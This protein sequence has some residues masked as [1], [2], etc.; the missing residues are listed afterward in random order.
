MKKKSITSSTSMLSER[1]QSW[2]LVFTLPLAFILGIYGYLNYPMGEEQVSFTNAM[3]HAAQLFI[4]HT[5]HFGPPVP[6]SLEIARWLAA[7]STGLVL[8]NAVLHI[9]HR[10]RMKMV[11]KLRKQHAIVCGLGRRGIAVTEKLNESGIPVVAID[12]NPEPE[13]VE[14]LHS[15]G[16]PLIIGD[17]TRKE[18]LQQARIEFADHIYTLCPDDTTN[19]SIALEAHNIKCSTGR[20]RE[21]FIHINDA[22]LRNVLQNNYQDKK[23]KSSQILN[24]IDAYSTEAISLLAHGLPLDHDGIKAN[25]NRKVHLVILGFGCMGRTIAVKAAQL[26]QFANRKR[27]R[28]SVI[29]RNADV[30]QSALFFHHPFIGDVADFSFYRQEVLSPKT[31]TQMEEW[32]TESGMLVNVAVCFDNPSVA[33]DTFFHLLPVF[34]RENVRVAIRVDE[35]ESFDFLLKGVGENASK[36]QQFIPFGTEKNFVKMIKPES[37][38]TEKFAIDIHKAYV[39]LITDEYKNNPDEL[40]KKR[41]SG[42]LNEWNDLNEDFRES[43]R[44]QAVHIFFKL[45]ACGFEVA[46]LEDPRPAIVE[47]E[48]ELLDALAIMEHDRWVA[49]RKVNNWKYGEVTDKPNR[50][51][52]NIVDWDQ[53]TDEIKKYDYNTVKMIPELLKRV[54]KK[55]VKKK[56]EL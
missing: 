7:A 27:I 32:C 30:S 12:N 2:I 28:I 47:F 19:I 53:L 31:R 22:E 20:T 29:D 4:M 18:I 9:F 44:Q 43:N 45:R 25:D 24:F 26:G 56:S 46:G 13:L 33:F 8:I 6:W 3:Y 48:N 16:I 21:C 51:S 23:S 39:E 35:S 34:N 54:G 11:L 55:M 15:L 38:Q 37:D 42:E 52:N 1:L 40:K 41:E 17:A 5:P 49:E 14:R 36:K 10:E 50:I